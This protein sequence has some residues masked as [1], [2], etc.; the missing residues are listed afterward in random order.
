MHKIPEISYQRVQV[1]GRILPI[2]AAENRKFSNRIKLNDFFSVIVENGNWDE[3]WQDFIGLQ[4]CG[5][6][7]FLKSRSVYRVDICSKRKVSHE[8]VC[9]NF[10]I[11]VSTKWLL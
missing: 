6:N 8:L 11:L 1:Y 10:G 7:K 4:K 9:L 5:R 2:K 3:S